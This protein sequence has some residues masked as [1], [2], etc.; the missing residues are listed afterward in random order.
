M[1]SFTGRNLLWH[2]LAIAL[3]YIIVTSGLDWRYFVFTRIPVLRVI[4][5]PAVVLGMFLPIFAP[6]LLLAAGAIG[7]SLRVKTAAHALGQSA[8]LGLAISSF[9][10]VFTG[11]IPPPHTFFPGGLIDT[12]HGFRL[13]FLRGGAFWGWPSSHTTVAFAMAVA[14]WKLYPQNRPLRYSALCYALYIGVGVSM[15]IH[16]FSEFAAGAIIG[17]LIGAVVGE[18]FSH[19]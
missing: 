14:L 5:F 2:A 10:K 19:S 15:T 3:T 9:Y 13:G 7:R 12:S 16:W 17:S 11:R 1:R 4:F 6:L 8:L 18:S